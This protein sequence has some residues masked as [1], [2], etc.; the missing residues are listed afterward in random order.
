[1][2]AVFLQERGHRREVFQLA[3]VS[4]AVAAAD[5]NAT[6]AVDLRAILSWGLH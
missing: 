2:L 6:I 5:D 1:M 3:A 4:Q